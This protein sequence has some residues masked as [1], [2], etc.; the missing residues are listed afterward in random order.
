[1]KISL[2]THSRISHDIK[3]H[4]LKCDEII[5]GQR[6]LILNSKNIKPKD[7]L[8]FYPTPDGITFVHHAIIYYFGIVINVSCIDSHM[9]VEFKLKQENNNDTKKA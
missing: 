7:K 5:A 3:L 9:I 1:M 4:T 8:N 6:F 2:K